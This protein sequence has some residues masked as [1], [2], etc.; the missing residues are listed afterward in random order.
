MKAKFFLPVIFFLS[1]K[2]I[3]Q[4][5]LTDNYIYHFVRKGET[6]WGIAS[7]YGISLKQILKDNPHINNFLIR[8]GD[9]IKISL[10]K[11]KYTDYEENE[12]PGFIIRNDTI[13]HI[14]SRKETLYRLSKH[15]GVPV[16]SIKKWNNL[17]Q[18]AIRAGDTLLIILKKRDNQSVTIP[19]PE[20]TLLHHTV[21]KGETYYSIA[22]TYN[23]NVDELMKLNKNIKADELKEGM[24]IRLPIKKALLQEKKTG[25]EDSPVHKPAFFIPQELKI[26]ICCADISDSIKREEILRYAGAFEAI[27][28]N[29]QFN[30]IKPI[31]FVSSYLPE[32]TLKDTL[33]IYVLTNIKNVSLKDI[34]RENSLIISVDGSSGTLPVKNATV[35][36]FP[37]DKSMEVR[38]FLPDF[39]SKCNSQN[40]II[41]R[42]VHDS[43]ID[44]LS[45]HGVEI[46][47]YL[48][49]IHI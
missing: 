15:Y 46:I 29:H 9:V 48:S 32:N 11:T 21:N 41:I 23:I 35:I 44:T 6:L 25:K 31:V 3:A 8:E 18:E 10:K 4:G 45:G 17:S 1:W 22:R 43:L 20:D 33:L 34:D 49:L 47:K 19:A 37:L 38:M 40:C 2:V 28:L 39:L 42:S 5:V 36:D 16:D 14:V 27:T 12:L 26:T 24:V 30:N 7:A 13:F